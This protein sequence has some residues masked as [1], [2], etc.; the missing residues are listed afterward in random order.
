MIFAKKIMPLISKETK[1]STLL[2]I[3]YPRIQNSHAEFERKF[4]IFSH[5]G[6]YA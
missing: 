2:V 1:C 4:I 5:V 6:W 3:W